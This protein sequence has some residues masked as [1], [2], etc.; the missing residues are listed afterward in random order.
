MP[1][2]SS[3]AQESLASKSSFK[4]LLALAGGETSLRSRAYGYGKEEA[5]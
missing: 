4:E 3:Y 5:K 2:A 1:G